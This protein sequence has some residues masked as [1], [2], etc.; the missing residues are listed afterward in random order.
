[1]HKS[2]VMRVFLVAVL[3]YSSNSPNWAAAQNVE[4]EGVRP[5]QPFHTT[6][7]GP[8]IGHLVQKWQP[9][10]RAI[11]DELK[12]VAACSASTDKCL[13]DAA[14]KFRNIMIEASAYEGRPRLAYINRAVNLAI[15]YT[16]D[17]RAHG[18]PDHWAT[19]FDTLESG[20]GDC[21]D[22]AITK[23]ALLRAMNWPVK[24]L[25]IVLVY[26][27]RK[28]EYHAVEATHLGH[29]WLILDNALS[30]ISPD[31]KL[32]SYHPLF[33]ID[34]TAVRMLYRPAR[35]DESKID[36]WNKVE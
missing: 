27:S 35:A 28:R 15:K 21:E 19:P 33:V 30:A 2:A 20:K 7:A 32:P 26:I 14:V 31:T 29:N 18:I 3:S 23:F 12:T 11:Q 1:M 25:R 24:D 36:N 4:P 22:Y 13:S 5:D 34:E 9:V 8:P 10:E 16:S 17:T 6:T